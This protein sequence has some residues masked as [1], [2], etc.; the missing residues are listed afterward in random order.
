MVDV[1][2]VSVTKRSSGALRSVVLVF[3]S[4]SRVKLRNVEN[5][6]GCNFALNPL[7][8]ELDIYS[9]VHHLCKM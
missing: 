2:W 5:Y 6:T 9:L 1:K 4:R 7:A 8:L 3:A